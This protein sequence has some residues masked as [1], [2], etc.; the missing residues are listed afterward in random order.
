MHACLTDMERWAKQAGTRRV[1]KLRHL[2]DHRDIQLPDG[3]DL[4]TVHH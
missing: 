2:A 4:F 3:Y 1:A